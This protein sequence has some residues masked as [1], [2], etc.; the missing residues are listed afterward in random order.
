M[1]WRLNMHDLLTLVATL[2]S[3][4]VWFVAYNRIGRAARIRA[5][6]PSPSRTDGT[7][8]WR[9]DLVPSPLAEGY[10]PVSWYLSVPGYFLTYVVVYGVL[11]AFSTTIYA[12]VTTQQGLAFAIIQTVVGW[13]AMFAL[14]TARPSIKTRAARF[15]NTLA[16]M[17]VMPALIVLVWGV[18]SLAAGIGRSCPALTVPISLKRAN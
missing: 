6:A 1:P 8:F 15:F 11:R 16:L 13:V 12:A 18:R 5:A 17:V 4:V 10:T 14:L 7:P 2:G 3:V 9:R